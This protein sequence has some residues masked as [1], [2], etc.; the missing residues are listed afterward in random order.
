MNWREPVMCNRRKGFMS[1]ND[2]Y[3][4]DLPP[5]PRRYDTPLGDGLVF[6]VFPNG[7][8]CWVLVY[9]AGGFTRR[10]TLG[11]YPEM[12]LEDARGAAGQ[13]ARVIEVEAELAGGGEA[14][15]AA[16][17]RSFLAGLLE[18][19]P[20]LAVALGLGFAALLGMTV[21]WLLG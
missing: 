9:S 16:N 19:R 21:V 14:T 3:F 15:S 4:R 2:D 7:T 13:A 12:K 6:S 10:R 20:L 8:K 17:R 1:L 5:K 18:D 11:L